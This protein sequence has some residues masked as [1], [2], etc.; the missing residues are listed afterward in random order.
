MESEKI[1]EAFNAISYVIQNRPRPIPDADAMLMKTGD[2]LRQAA[3]VAEWAKDEK[4]LLLG[5][6]DMIGIGI[7]YLRREGITTGA[8]ASMLV[9]DHDERIVSAVRRFADREGIGEGVIRSERYNVVEPLDEDWRCFT[10]FHA[11]PP[12]GQD[13]GGE[14]VKVF[15]ERGFEAMCHGGQ[16]VLILADED[17]V[18]W[19]A[20]VMEN[21][22]RFALESGYRVVRIDAQ[23]HAYH[24]GRDVEPLSSN[25]FLA[26]RAGNHRRTPS[27]PIDASRLA[28]FYGRGQPPRTR[29]I[30][31]VKDPNY[32]RAS[33][34]EYVLEPFGGVER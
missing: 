30:T 3:L 2:V 11:N 32:G 24:H 33:P 14:S 28:D 12:W 23:M 20:T 5:D 27:M 18:P 26:A 13:N 9:L 19:T 7:A 15:A 31:E 34:S 16:G 6:E 17:D 4:L 21:V 10:R 1:E 22:Q 29:Y 25:L 8:P